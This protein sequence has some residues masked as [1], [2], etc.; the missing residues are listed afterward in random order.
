MKEKRRKIYL[1]IQEAT[2]MYLLFSKNITEKD[3]HEHIEMRNKEL[4]WNREND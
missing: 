1:A 2:F 3:R 4:K